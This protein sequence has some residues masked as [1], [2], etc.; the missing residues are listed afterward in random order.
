MST[1][2]PPHGK[3]GT[4]RKLKAVSALKDVIKSAR[5]YV[6]AER[7]RVDVDERRRNAAIADIACPDMRAVIRDLQKNFVPRST[8]VPL[9]DAMLRFITLCEAA[10]AGDLEY[11]QRTSEGAFRLNPWHIMLSMCGACASSPDELVKDAAAVGIDTTEHEVLA[12][13]FEHPKLFRIN[14]CSTCI[15]SQQEHHKNIKLTLAGHA[16]L[17]DGRTKA[18]VCPSMHGK[19]N[20]HHCH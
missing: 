3:R 16:V 15:A 9:S 10:I 12:I 6:G 14:T 20:C 8:L 19:H 13:A 1:T 11:I 4:K 18:C 7:M 17:A 5:D 2:S